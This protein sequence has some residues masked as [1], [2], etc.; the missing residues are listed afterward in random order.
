MKIL[1]RKLKLRQPYVGVFL[2]TDDNNDADV[3]RNLSD[4]HPVGTFGQIQEFQDLGDKLR[5]IVI[6]HRRIK[7]TNQLYEESD[8]TA[9]T[10]KEKITLQLFGQEIQVS[11]NEHK[12]HKNEK[13]ESEAMKRRKRHKRFNKNSSDQ[14]TDSID[15]IKPRVLADGEQQSVLMVEVE[16]VKMEEFKE[17]D[18]V[19]A[20][21]QEVIKTLRDII[22][23]NSLYRENLQQMIHLNQRVVNNPV[24]LCDLGAS[25][26][27]AEPSELQEV[28]HEEDVSFIIWK[29]N[30]L[31]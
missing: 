9:N 11:A 18:E 26:A 29:L 1:R 19:K 28:L 7:I 12:N 24:Y 15:E 23:M 13:Y 14:T 31:V 10:E 22:S 21:T 8:T 20:L 25:L 2:K 27:A 16:N 4:I 30:A 17:T 3:V 6:A 5:M